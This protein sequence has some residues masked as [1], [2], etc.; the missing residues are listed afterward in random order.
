[1]AGLTVGRVM[2]KDEGVAHKLERAATP[3][4]VLFEPRDSTCG[5]E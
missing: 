1:V 2:S 4:E 3:I 5:F